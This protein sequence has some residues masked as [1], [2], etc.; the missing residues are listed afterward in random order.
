MKK[1]HMLSVL[2]A[3][4][5]LSGAAFAHGGHRFANLDTNNDGKV[6]LAEAEAGA[7]ARFVKLDKNKDGVI[8]QDELG[9][10]PHPMMKRADANNDGKITLA[11][12]QA[13]TQTWFGR[14]DKNNDKVITKD[15]LAAMRGGHAEHC[16][17][18]KKS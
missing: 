5:A 18:D 8:S 1:F 16:D 15:E 12:L 14:L 4:T 6:T 2:A 9:D 11:E 3:M 13:Q 10:G 17:H 7:Q